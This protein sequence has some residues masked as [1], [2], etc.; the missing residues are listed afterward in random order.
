MCATLYQDRA[1]LAACVLCVLYART[2][3]CLAAAVHAAV[4]VA[5]AVTVAVVECVMY[6]YIPFVDVSAFFQ[7]V[8]L[9]TS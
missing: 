8:S 2:H 1:S 5:V 6:E 4:A 3:A 7:P 9:S